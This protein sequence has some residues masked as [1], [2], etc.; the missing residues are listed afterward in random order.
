MKKN[1]TKLVALS[2]AAV[3]A[4]SLGACGSSSSGTSSS[5]GSSSGS[6]AAESSSSGSSTAEA[7]SASS[8]AS[9]SDGGSSSGELQKL[10]WLSASWTDDYCKRLSDAIVELGPD[11]GFEVNA[12]NGAPDGTPDVSKYMEG[13]DSLL[14]QDPDAM[15]VQP[16][17]TLPDYCMKF[18]GEIP[19]TFINIA[20]EISDTSAD[21]QYWY[22]GCYDT[23]IGEQLAEEMA[24]GLKEGAKICMVNLT[25]GQTNAS[26]RDE[27]FKTWMSENR[28]DVEILET[29]WVEKIDPQNA[30]TAFEDWIQKYGVG[31]FDGVATQGSMLTQGIVECMKKYDLDTSNFTLAGISASTTEWVKDGLEFVE[32]YQDPYA[33][34]AAALEVT[35]A[36]LDGT[37]DQLEPMEGTDNVVAVP[38]T[39]ITIDNADEFDF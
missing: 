36:Q 4:L 8:S 32:L 30:Q 29:H 2:M 6:S 10:G 27:G 3:V 38:M 9:S 33:E 24:K 20:P 16:L 12:L 17:F 37:T 26:Q 34:A 23:S 28:P 11:Y 7:S 35:R 25:Y 22:A 39:P 13:I 18:N 31:G 19:L 1:M 14:S 5:S 21:L 15:L